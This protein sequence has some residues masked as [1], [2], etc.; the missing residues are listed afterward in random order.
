MA[1]Q[2]V[3][4]RLERR[5]LELEREDAQQQEFLRTVAQ[6][7]NV[8]EELHKTTVYADA[9]D[10]FK[11]IEELFNDD[12]EDDVVEV[13]MPEAPQAASATLLASARPAP[14]M[15]GPAK[16]PRPR[17][18]LL[19]VKVEPRVAS[20]LGREVMEALHKL[21][22]AEAAKATAE[23]AQPDS[24]AAGSAA[25]SSGAAGSGQHGGSQHDD[26]QQGGKSEKSRGFQVT[27]AEARARRDLQV[28]VAEGARID[29]DLRKARVHDLEQ[30]VA[31]VQQRLDCARQALTE[32]QVTEAKAKLDLDAAEAGVGASLFWRHHRAYSGWSR[33][34]WA[35][36]SHSAAAQGLFR[37]V[38][39][40]E[41]ELHLELSDRETQQYYIKLFM[42]HAEKGIGKKGDVAKG[43]GCKKGDVAKGRSR[44]PP[45]PPPA[46]QAPS[47]G[48][49]D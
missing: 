2:H 20:D 35:L 16:L 14:S 22:K 1:A 39:P 7:E 47:M 6:M 12:E 13:T 46:P 38:F 27:I 40:M 8:A 34:N 36:Y 25:G 29:A 41:M 28:A 33:I 11:P 15:P 10:V 18:K 17:P 48:P 19:G 26:V 23:A 42:D 45:T 30:E 5:R 49:G 37:A 31:E 9:T 32:A 44:S 21:N 43:K 4:E 3:A 24:G